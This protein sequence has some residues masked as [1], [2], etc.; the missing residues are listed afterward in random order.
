MYNNNE[1]VFGM[2]LLNNHLTLVYWVINN[3]LIQ[4]TICNMK[5]ER[6]KIWKMKDED[7]V[8]KGISYII[9]KEE[10]SRWMYQE[11]RVAIILVNTLE[12]RLFW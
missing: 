5:D 4:C 12:H 2:V 10:S 8:I 3:I 6:W 9:Y 1:Q 7:A 11:N